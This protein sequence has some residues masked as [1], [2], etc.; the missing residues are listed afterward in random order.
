[1]CSNVG[2]LP[3]LCGPLAGCREDVRQGKARPAH[4][5][6]ASGRERRQLT[7]R[8]RARR[9][10]PDSEFHVAEL[11]R[12]PLSDDCADV[13][14]ARLPSP[15]CPNANRSWP[16]LP[17]R[18]APA[19]WWPFGTPGSGLDQ[20]WTRLLP[21]F[22]GMY[23]SF[24]TGTGPGVVARAYPPANLARLRGLKRLDAS[25]ENDGS[26]SPEIADIVEQEWLAAHL[27]TASSGATSE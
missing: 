9:W 10:V 17:A 14:S 6:R 24:E 7:R 5:V 16:T 21:Q 8:A 13:V 3:G 26:A 12:L 1:V 27:V 22:E 23:L 19:R 15:T 20:A 4:P 2:L 11:D 18:C 25:I